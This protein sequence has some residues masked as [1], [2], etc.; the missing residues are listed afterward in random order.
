MRMLLLFFLFSGVVSAG[1]LTLSKGQSYT[2]P[3]GK[4]WIIE[5][6][7]VAEC[8][9]CTADVYAK[10]ELNN[11]QVGGVTFSGEFNFSFSDMPNGPIKLFPGTQISLGDSRRSLI[12]NET[13]Q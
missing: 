7:P 6:A 10:G 3:E 5:S 11:I 13:E 4:V 2:V 9:V 8:R 1:E 12:V